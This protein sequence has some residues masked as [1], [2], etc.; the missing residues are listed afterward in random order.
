[1]LGIVMLLITLIIFSLQLKT[2]QTYLAKKAAT[3]LSEEWNTRVDVGALYIKPF[4]SLVLD[5]LYVQDLQKDTLLF[6]KKLTLDVG[7]FSL[8]DRKIN[9]K[10][11]ELQ[12]GKFFFKEI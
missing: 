2:V 12:E 3:F 1:M 10:A 11:I 6:T 5:S 4:K 7:Y 8:S 9:I